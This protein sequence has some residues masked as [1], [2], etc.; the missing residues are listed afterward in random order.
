MNTLFMPVTA[1][2]FRNGRSVDWRLGREQ[3][4]KSEFFLSYRAIYEFLPIYVQV[5]FLGVN[6]LFAIYIYI[7]KNIYYFINYT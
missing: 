6:W 2:G 4:K 1:G 5:G 3:P 7:A